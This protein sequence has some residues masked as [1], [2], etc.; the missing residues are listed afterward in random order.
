MIKLEAVITLNNGNIITIDYRDIKSL[1]SQTLDR[2]QYENVSFGVVSSKNSIYILDVRSTLYRLMISKELY[3]GEKVEFFILN[4]INPNKKEL[5]NTRYATDW[6]YDSLDKT[7]SCE[8]SDLLQ[9]WQQIDVPTA[10]SIFRN[11]VNIRNL[12]YKDA[13]NILYNLTPAKYNMLSFEELDSKTK[14]VLEES[15]IHFYRRDDKNLWSAWNTLANA[16]L[17]HIFMDER[18]KTIFRYNLGD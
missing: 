7:V 12:T 9:D 4:S 10:D 17:C 5:I 8:L 1:K 14:Q 2:T 11:E 6:K 18:S 13:Y 15:D 16:S 3:Y